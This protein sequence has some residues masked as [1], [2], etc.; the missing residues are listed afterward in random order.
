M[1]KMLKD[2]ILIKKPG[3]IDGLQFMIK[4]L[5]NCSVFL[6]DHTAQITVD[7]CKNTK[8]YIGPIKA[9]IF[10]RDCSDCEITVTTC[11]FRCRDLVDSTIYVYSP[12]EPIIESS[13]NLVFAP[14]NLKYPWLKEHSDKA[15]V[16]GQFTD[17]DGIVQQ[18]VNRWNQIHDFTKRSDGGLNYRLLPPQ[19]FAIQR[20]EDLGIDL[21]D[22]PV[23]FEDFLYELPE[24]Y[25]GSLRE[26]DLQERKNGLMAFDIRTGMSEAQK[27]F[28]KKEEQKEKDKAVAA[29][30]KDEQKVA[31]VKEELA[32]G[33]PGKDETKA[34][35]EKPVVAS[36]NAP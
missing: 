28:E 10:F 17:D 21:Q 34:P 13:K 4:D 20:L 27:A 14:Y 16:V 15:D 2:Q 35:N 6:M 22:P 8:F 36:T 31:Q 23:G 26:A 30:N 32:K 5:E 29:A 18:K 9:S 25:G 24:E 3:D 12:N 7:R 33:L 19:E 11:Q 1:F